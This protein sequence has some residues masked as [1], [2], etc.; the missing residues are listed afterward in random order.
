MMK[1]K[2]ATVILAA[3]LIVGMSAAI[4]SARPIDIPANQ[5]ERGVFVDPVPAK[6]NPVARTASPAPGKGDSHPGKGKPSPG[7]VGEL[8][9][10]FTYK[11]LHWDTPLVPYKVNV[12]SSGL[13]VAAAEQA[14]WD[15]F[16][17][18]ED[19]VNTLG[20][21]DISDI[22]Y[23]DAGTTAATGA[24]LDGTVT[25]SWGPLSSGTIAATY[26]WYDRRSKHLLDCDIIFNSN[27]PWST[28]G[29]AGAYDVW[30]IG[31]HEVGHTLQL[32]DLYTSATR[33]LTMYGYGALGETKKQTL[34]MG[35]MLGVERIYPA[36]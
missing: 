25:V 1:V 8:N 14:V 36:P 13:D 21:P 15:S 23:L 28:S 6:G 30:N 7:G 31:A 3:V 17:T 5:I 4:A 10:S 9:T 22:D 27:L 32:N 34:G 33:E 20:R 11:G 29:A 35:D 18:W 24:T 16:R 19:E 2:L 26:Y 12:T